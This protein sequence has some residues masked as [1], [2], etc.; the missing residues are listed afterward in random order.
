MLVENALRDAPWEV[1]ARTVFWS[2]DVPLEAWRAGVL[3]GHR[4]YLPESVARMSPW[5]FARFLGRKT[6]VDRWPHI[7]DFLSPDA[8][9]LARLDVA[10]SYAATG[11]FNMPPQAAGME[12][13]DRSREIPNAVV[14]D[15]GMSIAEVTK[16]LNVSRHEA[17]AC[18]AELVDLELVKARLSGSDRCLD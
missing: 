18:A 5:N 14:R 1:V 3:A 12:L 13:S 16:L 2:K 10:W 11:S 15:Q 4:S 17:L 8:L 9:G 6:F 7:R